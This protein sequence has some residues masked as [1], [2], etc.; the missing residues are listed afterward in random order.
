MNV[1][2]VKNLEELR[3]VRG[4]LGAGR[5]DIREMLITRPMRKTGRADDNIQDSKTSNLEV[6]DTLERG[7]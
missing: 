7:A 3:G 6:R 1:T 4:R 5:V 2:K